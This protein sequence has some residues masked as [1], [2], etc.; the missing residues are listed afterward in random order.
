MPFDLSQDEQRLRNKIETSQT[1]HNKLLDL[2]VKRFQASERVMSSRYDAWRKAEEQHLAYVNEDDTDREGNEWNPFARSIVVPYTYAIMQTRL[3]FFFLALASKNPV[4]PIIGNGPDDILPAKMH[5]IINSYQINKNQGLSTFYC[6][7]QDSE[8]YGLGVVKNIWMERHRERWVLERQ[9]IMVLGQQMAEKKVRVRKPVTEYAGNLQINVHPTDFYPDT[10]VNISHFQEGEFVI[11]RMRLSHSH[12]LEK[13]R[14]GVYFNEEQILKVRGSGVLNNTDVQSDLINGRDSSLR[15]IMGLT[16]ASPMGV[17]A[18]EGGF[19][20]VKECWVRLIPKE[21]GLSSYQYPELWVFTVV[22]NKTIIG[23][24]RCMY[25]EYPFYV[26]ESNYDYGSPLNMGTPELNMG[27]QKILS[28]MFNSRVDNVQKVLNDVFV[29]DPSKVDLN[30]LFNPSPVKF[31]R[32]KES[33]YGSATLDTAIKQLQV[34]DVTASHLADIKVIIDLM[35]RVSAATDNVMGMTEEVKRTATETSS[36]IQLA[37]SRLKL[38]LELHGINGFMPLI[39]AM[40]FNNQSFM[41]EGQYYRIT[42]RTAQ[43]LGADAQLIKNRLFI[44]PVDL[45]GNFD[46][47]VPSLDLPIDRAQ[48]AEVWR[49]IIVDV[50][51]NPILLQEYDLVPMMQHALWNL[52]VRDVSS[53]RRQQPL[54][55]P[56]MIVQPDQQ[57]QQQVQAGN[58]VPASNGQRAEETAHKLKVAL[59]RRMLDKGEVRSVQ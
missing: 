50:T 59:D 11:Q 15:R 26:L 32:L 45:Y 6:W 49:Q 23:A 7:L 8:R 25:S 38:L 47:S 19:H 14:D 29:L 33:M 28:W 43:E 4:I 31:I 21:Y 53:F 13:V 51:Q 57:V 16:E 27:L 3:T 17:D 30:D 55:Q 5:E 36:T 10:R 58:L 12:I 40:T 24:D 56:Q 42:D 1:F 37:T 35:Q 39:Q 46:F 34:Q 44:D 9:P 2:C 48:M 54:Q 18:K 20:D 41:S 52:G 22:D